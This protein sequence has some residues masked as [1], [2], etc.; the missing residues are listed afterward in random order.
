MLGAVVAVG[1]DQSTVSVLCALQDGG[2]GSRFSGDGGAAAGEWAQATMFLHDERDPLFTVG[3]S[4]LRPHSMRAFASPTWKAVETVISCQHTPSLCSGAALSDA[5]LICQRRGGDDYHSD[6][7]AHPSCRIAAHGVWM[8]S[9]QRETAWLVPL[10]MP[11]VEDNADDGDAGARII[12]S[13][14]ARSSGRR[15]LRIFDVRRRAASSLLTHSAPSNLRAAAGGDARTQ[16][17]PR[18]SYVHPQPHC[19]A[20]AGDGGPAAAH[21]FAAATCQHVGLF[22]ASTVQPT[23][24][25]PLPGRFS[26]RTATTVV[27]EWRVTSVLESP[28][29]ASTSLEQL[30]ANELHAGKGNAYAYLVTVSRACN[31]DHYTTAAAVMK[32]RW[33]LFYDCRYPA[34][35]VWTAEAP[36]TPPVAWTTTTTTTTVAAAGGTVTKSEA[37]SWESS[38]HDDDDSGSSNTEWLCSAAPTSAPTTSRVC[39]SY[40]SYTTSGGRGTDVSASAAACAPPSACVVM[41]HGD[42]SDA[43]NVGGDDDDNAGNGDFKRHRSNM[44]KATP[45]MAYML[46]PPPS[47]SS[48]QA[49]QLC[50]V[51]ALSYDNGVL[52]YVCSS[53]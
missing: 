41:L 27:G 1:D 6:S 40:L 14:A 38:F 22:H 51:R 42:G 30:P 2:S 49:G 8:A 3:T 45:P 25:F 13:R 19:K 34:A 18:Q 11:E 48:A 16:R 4:S 43:G 24:L 28:P 7:V 33:W 5:H 17:E 26:M 39:A 12:A 37:A 36:R 44:S 15:G 47:L 20:P 29:C 10:K 50:R 52:T 35:P 32:E 23:V 31:T 9:V 21:I 46:S 53:S